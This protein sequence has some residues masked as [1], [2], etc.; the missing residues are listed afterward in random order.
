MAESRIGYQH[1]GDLDMNARRNAMVSATIAVSAVGLICFGA[2]EGPLFAHD[3]RHFSAGE[4]GSPKRSSRTIAVTMTEADGKMLFS[5]GRIEVRQGEQI[6]FVLTNTG[7]LDHEFMIG[8]PDENKEH[9]KVMQK[10]THMQHDDPNG[11]TVKPKQTGELIWRFTR[12]GTFE[13]ACLIPGHYEA[14]MYGTIVVK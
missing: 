11:R 10:H 2:L 14:G 8:T 3:A 1:R 9:A 5:P 6:K 4:P 13:F 7:H 12:H